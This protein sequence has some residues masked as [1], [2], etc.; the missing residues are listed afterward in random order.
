MLYV[1]I[2]IQIRFFL[3]H[4]NYIKKNYKNVNEYGN[5]IQLTNPI[6]SSL[7]ESIIQTPNAG[8]QNCGLEKFTRNQVDG[9]SI[10]LSKDQGGRS[11]LP[12]I[13]AYIKVA[14]FVIT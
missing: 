1:K 6:R 8:N 12:F 7:L 5:P 13:N 3:Q 4:E 10:C 9:K 14:I 2:M 11:V